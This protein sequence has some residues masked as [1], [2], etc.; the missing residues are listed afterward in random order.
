MPKAVTVCRALLDHAL[1]AS[2]MM[3]TDQATQ[4]AEV[5][6][7]HVDAARAFSRLDSY[8]VRRDPLAY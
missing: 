4:D 7:E 2:A 3:Q 5:A 1:A 8:Q 6:R